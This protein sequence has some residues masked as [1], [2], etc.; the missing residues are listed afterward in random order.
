MAQ[1]TQP[2]SQT[3]HA[4]AVVIGET[5]VLI[6][7]RSGTG[8]S[9]FA[10]RLIDRAARGGRFARL[11]SDD[12]VRLTAIHGRLLAETVAPIAGLLEVR[13]VG[14]V[15]VP[16]EPAA[17]IGMVVDVDVTPPRLPESCDKMTTVLEIVLPRLAIGGLIDAADVV[18]CLVAQRESGGRRGLWLNDDKMN[19]EPLHFSVQC[20]K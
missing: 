13:G 20:T 2:R 16:H 19:L 9:T 17:V 11:V 12:R 5:G 8:K 18:D 15:R 3:Q 6:R 1:D 10:R 7:G 14:I 4:T